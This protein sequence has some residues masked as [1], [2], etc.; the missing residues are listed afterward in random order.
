MKASAQSGF[1]SGQEGGWR[2]I[3]ALRSEIPGNQTLIFEYNFPLTMDPQRAK[4]YRSSRGAAM[5]RSEPD[6]LRRANEKFSSKGSK[7][8]LDKGKRI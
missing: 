4:I 7:K 8:A 2:E 3:W 1:R 6:H 5:K